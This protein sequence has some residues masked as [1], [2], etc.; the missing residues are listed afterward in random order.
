MIY[1]I[2]WQF[3]SWKTA[4]ST[5][6]AKKI[7]DT[8]N[9][10][11]L[12]HL[13][14][15]W[16]LILSN[17]HLDTNYFKN[18]FYFNDDDLLDIL[19]TINLVNDFERVLYTARQKNSSILKYKRERFSKFYIFFDESGAMMNNRKYKEFDNVF[20]EY[21][22]QNRKL[23]TDIYLVSA[24]WEQNEKSFRRFVDRWYYVTPLSK[25]I[26]F[27]KDIWIIRR[28][29]KDSEWKPLLQNYVWKDQNGDYVVKYRPVDEY[30]DFFYK[31]F[32]WTYYDD[33][34]KNIKDPKKYQIKNKD[35]V[36]DIIKRKKELEAPFNNFLLTQK[37]P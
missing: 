7:Q 13:S 17:I 36:Y 4:T 22:N 15:S 30:Y 11:I 32:M 26:P 31:P 28:M 18:Y 20:S 33:L 34:H 19:R 29:K 6:F 3:G 5:Y 35:L 16:N 12:K 8:S 14:T 24:D 9:K 21:V 1:W 10:K 2:E 23:F 37:A 27:L 25:Y